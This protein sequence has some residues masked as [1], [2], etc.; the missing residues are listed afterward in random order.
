[1]DVLCVGMY[2]ACSTWQYEVVAHLVERHRGGQRLGYLTGEEYA[3]IDDPKRGG[4]G[5]RVLKSHEGH[6]RF[7]TA[8]AKGRARAIYAHRDLRDVVFSLMHKRGLRFE[9]LLRQG[10]IHQILANDRFWRRQSDVLVQ[11]YEDLIADPVAGVAE[12][13]RHLGIGLAVDEAK[14]IAREYSFQANRER[15]RRLDARLRAAGINLERSASAPYY[16]PETLLHLN[17]M[18]QGR[19]GSWRTEA[20]F[21]QR[22][23]LARIGGHWL[24]SQAYEAEPAPRLRGDLAASVVDRAA[25]ARG[26]LACTLR[27]LALRFPRTAR[28]AKRLLMIPTDPRKARPERAAAAIHNRLPATRSIVAARTRRAGAERVEMELAG[29]ESA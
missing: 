10:M 11:R 4:P 27:C 12:L 22:V 7:A 9:E 15:I 5:W 25:E 24:R 20:T 29:R 3:V 28:L 13:A 1:M 14:A 18:R 23:I 16:D 17:H 2:R 26:W 8:L 19:V 21:R 6:R